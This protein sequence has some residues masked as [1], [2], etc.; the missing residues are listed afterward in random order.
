MEI[1]L[2]K[3]QENSIGISDYVELAKI[4]QKYYT[5]CGRQS[6]SKLDSDM[7]HY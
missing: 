6:A 4:V 1:E 3:K 5:S 7:L 2:S